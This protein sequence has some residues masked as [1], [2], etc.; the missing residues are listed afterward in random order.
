MN[1]SWFYEKS[2]WSRF[3]NAYIKNVSF[4]SFWN[5]L[6]KKKVDKEL[7]E[8]ID[9]FLN[10][11]SYKSVSR[12][13]QNINIRHINQ[14]N[15][16]GIENFATRAEFDYFTFVKFDDQSIKNIIEK[17][18]KDLKIDSIS[19][20]HIFRKYK[21]LNY[22]QS[23]NYNIILNLLYSYLK[24][25]SD[26]SLL[27]IYRDNNYLMEK[28]PHIKIDGIKINHDRINSVLEYVNIKTILDK[29]NDNVNIV[30]IGAGA[31]RVTE[32]ILSHQKDKN[33][34][35]FIVD[36]PPAL[37]INYLR[38]KKNF[39]DKRIGIANN[40]NSTSELTNFYK[41]NDIIFLL[42]H[43]LE[44]LKDININLFVAIDCLHEMDKT[45]IK[46]YME[47]AH[48]LSEHFYFK[49]WDETYVPYSFKNFL[50]ASDE[51]SYYIKS[52]WQKIYKKE[53]VFPS[54]FYE[55]CYKIK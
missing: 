54:N 48:R 24:F 20:F 36:I 18:D 28:T 50:S 53:S 46:Y 4:K 22:T 31:G 30:E 39:S 37:Y 26:S 49:I 21:D 3:K 5:K 40:I 47:N 42:P 16:F 7:S 55:F 17:F 6:D 41:N 11:K 35:Y 1:E 2:F 51:K 19:N 52:S 15:E 10:S 27:E 25:Y 34:K 8:M 23:I 44:I 12:F 38:V 29:Y 32:T 43:Q 45:S 9:F 14:I 33:I 13:W